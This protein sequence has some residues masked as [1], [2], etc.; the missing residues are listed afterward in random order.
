MSLLSRHILRQIA[1]PALLTVTVIGVIGVANEINE[2]IEDLPLTRVALYD[3]ARLAVYFLPSIVAYIIPVTYM[4]GILLAFGRLAHQGELIAM[5]AAGIPLRRLLVPVIAAAAILSAGCFVLQDTV[6]P[7]AVKRA[8]HLIY[9]ELPQRLS[10]DTIEPDRMHKAGDWR[11]YAGGKDHETG[12]LEDI[13]VVEA[14]GD[15]GADVYLADSARL[16]G[17]QG[18]RVLEM[19][20]G[21][22]IPAPDDGN[23][24]H[25]KFDHLTL[26]LATPEKTEQHKP[27]AALNVRELIAREERL[28]KEYEDSGSPL[29]EHELAKQRRE[30][31]ERL[32]LPFACLAVTLVAAPLGAKAKR[33][34]RSLTFAGGLCIVVLYY[35]LKLGMAS[36]GLHSLSTEIVN[37]WI[38]NAAMILAGVFL[39][40]WVDRV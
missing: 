12:T 8:F 16:A 30:I 6:Q 24:V 13:V 37:A 9:V 38:P 40:A 20:G 1:A 11:L 32:S 14:E 5:K 33:S 29:A 35:V 31:A 21:H 34:G 22:F 28:E 23:I 25:V 2:R 15:G 18:Q 3:L 36:Q 7:W 4:V 39:T 27:R 26:P 10:L 19:P 17:A